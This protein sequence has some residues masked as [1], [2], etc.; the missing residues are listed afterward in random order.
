MTNHEIASLLRK[1][2]ASYTVINEQK[3]RFQIIAYQKAAESIDHETTQVKDLVKE[4][5]LESLPGVGPSIRQHLEELIKTGKVKHFE[6]VTKD[7]PAALFPLLSIPSFGPKKAFKLVNHFKLK[8]PDTVLEDIKKLAEDHRIAELPGFGDKSEKDI[9]RALGEYKKGF[10]KTTRMVLPYASQI[11]DKIIDYLKKSPNVEAEFPLGSL[12]RKLSTVGDI[13]IAVSSKNPKKA[14]D[15]F[16]SYPYMGRVI[17]QG[18]ISASIL[19]SGGQQVDVMVLEPHR[20]GS[21]LQHFTGS[22]NHNVALREFAIRKGLSLSEKGIKHSKSGKVDEFDTEEKFYNALGMDWIPP[23]IREDTGEVE[24][25]L[26]HNLPKLVQLK[27]I[28]G[29]LHIHSSYP[30]EPS[31]D[32]GNNSMEEMLKK[33]QELGYEYLAFSEHNPNLSKHTKDQLYSIMA[34]RK[35]K[36]EQLKLKYKS[37]RII[38]LLETDILP[39]GNLAIDEKCMGELDAT[40]VSIHSVFKMDKEEMTKRVLSGLSHPKAKILTH[41]TG[42]LLNERNGYEL[43]FEKIFDFCKQHNK[44]LEINAWP[45]RLDLPDTLVRQAVGHGIKMVID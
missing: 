3:Y 39:N 21:L 16:V 2:A 5:K 29:D 24:L 19:T 15:Y 38:N 33:A 41:P 37:I 11:A 23:E 30:I 31:H 32:M 12:R 43:D 14:I 17:E 44:A 40:L 36:I 42:R 27:D 13:D 34:R 28:K 20:F 4:N 26:K 22:K 10:G 7:V 6:T 45:Q 8:N 9:L 18:P 35:E 25:A 1:I